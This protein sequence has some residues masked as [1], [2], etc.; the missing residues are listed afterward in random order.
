MPKKTKEEKTQE[1]EKIKK[2]RELTADDITERKDIR[3]R[4]KTIS[5]REH[6]Y[7]M[8][9]FA[10]IL[11]LLFLIVIYY[12]L[13][14]WYSNGGF[15]IGL[16]R[17]EEK[18]YG[19]VLFEKLEDAQTGKNYTLQLNAGHIDYIDNISVEWIPKDIDEKSNG[20]S[21][22][23][24]DNY[25]AYTFYLAN[26][27]TSSI[28]YFYTIYI[29]DVIKNVDDA[30]R[31]MIYQNGEKTLYGK[32]ARNGNAENGTVPFLDENRVCLVGRHNFTP[33]TIDKYTIVIFI[34]GNDPECLDPLIGGEMKMHMEIQSS[35]N[36]RDQNVY[37][38]EVLSH[39]E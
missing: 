21:H 35:R 29:D 32:R 33:G 16:A 8:Y 18:E 30:M 24:D 28:S 38:N 1:E 3:D 31:I 34:E 15:V 17:D 4:G 9:K 5:N 19:I 20:G 12:L 26:K 27:G 11:C 39:I 10:L 37:T 23:L 36:D 7:K 2:Y 6:R 13:K 14:L 25:L 22:N